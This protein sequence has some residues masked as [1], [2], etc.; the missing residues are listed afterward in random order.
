MTPNLTGP[1]VNDW[2]VIR[3][4]LAQM[5]QILGNGDS[6]TSLFGTVPPPGGDPP[7]A[8][9]DDEDG[10]LAQRVESKIVERAFAKLF[11]GDDPW[12]V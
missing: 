10:Y 8:E 3:Q 5:I 9:R 12:E 11:P 2:T 7:G 1:T 6:P 4:A